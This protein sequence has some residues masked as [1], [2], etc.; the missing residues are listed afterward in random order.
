MDTKQYKHV[1]CVVCCLLFVIVCLPFSEKIIILA[2]V[3]MHSYNIGHYLIM[4]ASVFVSDLYYALWS[5]K[6][7]WIVFRIST[8]RYRTFITTNLEISNKKW[9]SNFSSS[10]GI[11]QALL[12]WLNLDID[13]I[14]QWIWF[15]MYTY[16]GY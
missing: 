14:N 7:K 11:W 13:S 4:F 10:I 5:I 1:D 12:Q 16:F 3:A 6:P 9:I 2:V 15:S 8:Y